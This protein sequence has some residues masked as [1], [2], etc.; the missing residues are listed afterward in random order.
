MAMPP[1]IPQSINFH[2]MLFDEKTAK[3]DKY[4]YNGEDKGMIWRH[5]VFDY[6]VSRCPE[7][8]VILGWAEEQGSRAI[9]RDELRA[10][11]PV[12]VEMEPEV[13]AHHVWGFLQ[14][15]LTH[16][17][18]RTFRNSEKRNGLEVWRQLTLEINS[19]TDCREH[20]LRDR[21][22][23][24]QQATD[25][26]GITHAIAAWE[27]DYNEYRDAGG[28]EMFF[29]EQR[30]QIL[31]LLPSGLRKDLFKVMHDY[32]SLSQIKEW[33]RV[34]VE[35]EQEWAEEDRAQRGQPRR[36][37]HV[38]VAEYDEEEPDEINELFPNAS[39]E[40]VLALQQ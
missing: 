26:K 23:R 30:G 37:Q 21:V 17:A 9:T 14:H 13:L 3:D 25:L 4:K 20:S 5:D 31:R 34:Q 29:K 35:L 39:Q 16:S 32:T 33:I 7:A 1:G 22:Q 18:L 27:T 40:Q 6:I 10:G 11:I 38:M 28:G 19:R 2:S 36:S 15:C 12:A 8:E 24:P